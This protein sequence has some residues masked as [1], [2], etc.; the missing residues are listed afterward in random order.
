MYKMVNGVQM[1]MSQSE[2]DEHNAKVAAAAAAEAA[3][4]AT[5]KYKD[6]RRKAY[7]AIGDQLDMLWH[8]MDTLEIPKSVAFYDALK[9]VKDAHPKPV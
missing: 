7:P 2:I 1:E 5:E 3:Y 9:A 6:D 4:I 8:S